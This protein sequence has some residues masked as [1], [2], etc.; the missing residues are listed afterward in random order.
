MENYIALLRAVNVG[1]TGKIKMTD[2]VLICEDLGFTGVKTYIASG[3]VVFR[4]RLKSAT[5]KKRLEAALEQR[6]GKS[7]P[8]MIRTLAEI[9]KVLAANPFKK[10]PPNFTIITFLDSSPPGDSVATAK[11]LVD[12]KISL[13]EREIYVL[14]GEGMSASKLKLAAAASGTGRNV[15]TVTKLRDMATALK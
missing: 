2:L 14:Y 7:I 13:G 8:V 15:N 11:H 4:S 5:V 6:Y 10:A 12:E 1:G 3:N 9:D